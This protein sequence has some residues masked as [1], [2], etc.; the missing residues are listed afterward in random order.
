MKSPE[1]LDI[2]LIIWTE[3]VPCMERDPDRVWL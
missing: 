1:L 3:C 2:L